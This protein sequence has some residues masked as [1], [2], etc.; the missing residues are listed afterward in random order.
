MCD[1]YIKNCSL[2][3]D[4]CN[5]IFSC[6]KCHDENSDHVLNYKEINIVICNNCTVEQLVT[7]HCCNCG[8][9]FGEY[10]CARCKS[11]AAIT[12]NN[13]Y[14]HCDQCDM[15]LTGIKEN[16]YHCD[17]CNF[18][19]LVSMKNNHKCIEN[20]KQ[21]LCTVCMGILVSDKFMKISSCDHFIHNECMTKLLTN[22]ISKCPLCRTT[23]AI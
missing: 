17:Q 20:L 6:R 4:C 9:Q 1:H 16:T 8:I 14:Y 22:N 21:E 5:K 19:L 15:C 3:T 23:I 18:C 13:Q 11:Y 2:V 12:P 7:N 10:Y